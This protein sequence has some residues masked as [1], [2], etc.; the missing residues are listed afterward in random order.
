MQVNMDLGH[1]KVFKKIAIC[2]G[3][4]LE[5]IKLSL[6]SQKMSKAFDVINVFIDYGG[7]QEEAACLCKRLLFAEI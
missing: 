2:F 6:L 3:T 1:I 7:I 4:R 5:I